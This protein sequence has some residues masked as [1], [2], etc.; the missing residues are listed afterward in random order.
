MQVGTNKTGSNSY[1]NIACL[2]RIVMF[3]FDQKF[4]IPL[5]ILNVLIFPIQPW[6][7]Q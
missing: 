3:F 2:G 7:Q 6:Y 5:F 1:I 4:C